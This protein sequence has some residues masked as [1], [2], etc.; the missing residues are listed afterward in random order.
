[1]TTMFYVGEDEHRVSVTINSKNVR[2]SITHSRSPFLLL[3]TAFIEIRA[4]KALRP[5]VIASLRACSCVRRCHTATDTIQ[6]L[7]LRERMYRFDSQDRA[8][9]EIMSIMRHN[10]SE[11]RNHTH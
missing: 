1:M 4:R 6:T 3:T 8:D 10:N 2:R 7:R 5:P 11:V 9:A